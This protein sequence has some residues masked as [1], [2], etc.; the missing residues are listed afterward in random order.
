MEY[1]TLQLNFSGLGWTKSAKS[2]FYH[3]RSGVLIVSVESVR[4]FVR[5]EY[6]N[7]RKP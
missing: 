6:D 7:F 4:L 1:Y 2:T 3:P 5:I